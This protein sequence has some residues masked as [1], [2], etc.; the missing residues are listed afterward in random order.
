LLP[1]GRLRRPHRDRNGRE[2][3]VAQTRPAVLRLNPA[4]AISA[5][6]GHLGATS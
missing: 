4:S 3:R 2:R 1:N 5:I 6:S